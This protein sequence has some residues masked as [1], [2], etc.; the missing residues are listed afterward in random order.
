MCRGTNGIPSGNG[1]ESFDVA[2]WVRVKH[3]VVEAS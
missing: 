1:S 2:A 3:D